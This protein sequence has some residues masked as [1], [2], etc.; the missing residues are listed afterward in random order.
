VLSFGPFREETQWR[1]YATV[2]AVFGSEPLYFVFY[3]DHRTIVAG[4]L[5]QVS[6]HP[7]PNGWKQFS[8]AEVSGKL[9]KYPDAWRPATDDWPHLYIN[10]PG[11]PAD[12]A[13]VLVA[14][15]ALSLILVA[16]NF[17]GGYKPNG[18]FFFLGAGFLLLETK[19]VTEFALF[20][21]STWQV[22]TLVFVVILL[23]ILAAN[24]L[25][26]TVFPRIHVPLCYGMLVAVLIVTYV[27]PLQAW[28]QSAPTF[29]YLLAGSYLGIPIVLAAM[30]FAG[31]FKHV[32]LGSAGLASNL[33]GAVLGGATEYLSLAYGIRSLALL[34][35]AMYGAGFLCW[36][37]QVRRAASA[38]EGVPPVTAPRNRQQKF[39]SEARAAARRTRRKRR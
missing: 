19:S 8:A 5:S 37:L 3:N 23:T 10:K 34:A 9:S 25:V 26:L 39:S 18:H 2:R 17:R 24:L 14:M 12:Y 16:V 1:Q 35:A 28:V 22:N 36:V 13:G 20:M 31:T 6:P 7:L 38:Q 30:L 4:D 15:I 27:W 33:I 11:I 32:L 29:R 21:G